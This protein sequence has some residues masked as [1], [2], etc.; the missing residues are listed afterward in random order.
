MFQMISQAFYRWVSNQD[1]DQGRAGLSVFT[2][3]FSLLTIIILL[4]VLTKIPAIH[5]FTGLDFG[6]AMLCYLPFFL[7]TTPA[8]LFG[9]HLKM[10]HLLLLTMGS[11]SSIFFFVPRWSRK[12][13]PKASC[14]SPHCCSSQP[15]TTAN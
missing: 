8:H 12:Q 6:P 14:S 4:L 7:F 13:R 10:E 1:E 9:K 2:V 15:C 3:L 5:R 11:S